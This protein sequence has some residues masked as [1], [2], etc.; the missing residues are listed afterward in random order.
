MEDSQTDTATSAVMAK[1]SLGEGIHCQKPWRAGS[2]A[3]RARKEAS[4]ADDGEIAGSSS[5]ALHSERNSSA[6]ER[7]AAQADKML[8]DSMALGRPRAPIQIFD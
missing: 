5:S 3:M 2:A 1:T 4:K 7:Q 8:L 6:R